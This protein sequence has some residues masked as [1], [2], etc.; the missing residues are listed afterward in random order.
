MEIKKQLSRCKFIQLAGIAT[1][2]AVAAAC[3]PAVTNTPAAPAAAITAPTV[4]TPKTVKVGILAVNAKEFQDIIAKTGFTK[5]TG[6]TV[7]IVNRTD[8]KETE[9]ARLASAFQAGTSP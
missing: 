9:L 8:T 4:L 2:G 1:V 6:I 3:A 5:Q 7:E